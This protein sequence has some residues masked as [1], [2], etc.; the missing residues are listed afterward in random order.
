[1]VPRPGGRGNNWP[2]ED[3][4][5]GWIRILIELFAPLATGAPVIG[6]L[7]TRP[8]TAATV[9]DSIRIFLSQGVAC[10]PSPEAVTTVFQTARASASRAAATSASFLLRPSPCPSS[11]PFQRIFA[12]NRF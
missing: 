6:T 5:E 12:T 3:A 9:T 2:K 1:M 7:F 4:I 10:E 11:R 8:K